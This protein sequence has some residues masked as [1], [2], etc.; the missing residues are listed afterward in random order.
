MLFLLCFF[1]AFLFGCT[2]GEELGDW[3]CVKLFQKFP[4]LRENNPAYEQYR[5]LV[6]KPTETSGSNCSTNEQGDKNRSSL[7]G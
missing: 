7:Q 5:H 1:L 2:L 4:S 6:E 3:I